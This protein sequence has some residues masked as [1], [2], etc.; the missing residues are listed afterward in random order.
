[1]TSLSNDIIRQQNIDFFTYAIK[2]IRFLCIYPIDLLLSIKLNTF[3]VKV[4][5]LNS[6]ILDAVFFSFLFKRPLKKLLKKPKKKILKKKNLEL[7]GI[8]PQP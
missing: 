5:F 4:F 1:M 6:K 7:T 8:E 2:K 3:L